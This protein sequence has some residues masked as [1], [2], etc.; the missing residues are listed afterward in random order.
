MCSSVRIVAGMKLAG[1]A[2]LPRGAFIGLLSMIFSIG[3]VQPVPFF[4]GRCSWLLN[5]RLSP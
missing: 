3:G 2:V 1:G 4:A 5:P